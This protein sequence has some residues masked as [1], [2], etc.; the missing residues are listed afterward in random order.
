[1]TSTLPSNSSQRIKWIYFIYSILN[2]CCAGAGPMAV[3]YKRACVH[4][5]TACQW[6]S[7][8]DVNKEQQGCL[9]PN[10]WP[11]LNLKLYAWGDKQMK[12]CFACCRNIKPQFGPFLLKYIYIYGQVELKV[13][14]EFLPKTYRKK[15]LMEIKISH[16]ITPKHKCNPNCVINVLIIL[17]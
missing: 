5:F 14:W 2:G 16:C 6:F 4:I 17:H 15:V 3:I 10:E 13:V 9:W 11:F 12:V 8:C 7:G 1:M